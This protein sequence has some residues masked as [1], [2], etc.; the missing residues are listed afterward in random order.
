MDGIDNNRKYKI[1]VSGF[2]LKIILES[3]NDERVKRLS[4]T[5]WENRNPNGYPP[6]YSHNYNAKSV[7]QVDSVINYIKKQI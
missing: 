3:L 6:N 7:R 1:E 5:P 2:D 4:K